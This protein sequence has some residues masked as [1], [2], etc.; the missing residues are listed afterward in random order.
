MALCLASVSDNVIIVFVLLG[1]LQTERK[2]LLLP[3]SWEF[4]YRIYG[5]REIMAAVENI[6]GLGIPF[7]T[8][9]A[10]FSSDASYYIPANIP[11]GA[12]CASYARIT[13]TAVYLVYKHVVY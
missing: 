10:D 12:Q 5:D 6:V 3:H 8:A 4:S 2:V 7:V 13:S 11:H 9:A 1:A